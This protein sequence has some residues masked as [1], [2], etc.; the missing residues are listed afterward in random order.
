MGPQCVNGYVTTEF[1]PCCKSDCCTFDSG[2]H[3]ESLTDHNNQHDDHQKDHHYHGT[4]NLAAT[5][6]A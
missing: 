2:C 6:N 3:Q 4:I 5:Q 1:K